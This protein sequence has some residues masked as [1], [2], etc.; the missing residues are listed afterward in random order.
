MGVGEVRIAIER[1]MLAVARD[2]LPDA[3]VGEARI[4]TERL[5][6]CL[7]GQCYLPGLAEECLS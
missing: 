3:E 5:M 6:S 1:L 7:G 2:Q 4:A